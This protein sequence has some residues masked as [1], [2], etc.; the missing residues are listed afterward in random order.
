MGLKGKKGLFFV[1]QP[2]HMRLWLPVLKKLEK[3]GMEI[4]YVTT[5]VYFP[6]EV[7]AL[8]YGIVPIYIE[9]LMS[10]EDLKT[11]EETYEKLSSKLADIHKK[12]KVFN[13]FSPASITQTLRHIVRE[14]ILFEKFLQKNKVDIIF[15]LH[16]FNIWSLRSM[17]QGGFGLT[18]EEEGFNRIG[19][20][21]LQL[22]LQLAFRPKLEI[23]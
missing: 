6:F 9:D 17:S 2:H 15:A 1:G 13:L 16:E 11:E 12:E 23:I 21:Q 3:K 10:P 18:E 8:S 4:L 7:S 22:L 20:F 19:W 5:H 14:T